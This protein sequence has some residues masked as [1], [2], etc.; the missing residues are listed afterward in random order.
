MGIKPVAVGAS[1]S[2]VKCLK[3]LAKDKKLTQAV[4]AKRSG[5]RQPTISNMFT[6]KTIPNL[7]TFLSLC[8]AIGLKPSEVCELAEKKTR[9]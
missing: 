4:M 3:Q 8:R 2:I 5:L 7:D 6:G 1:A 9:T